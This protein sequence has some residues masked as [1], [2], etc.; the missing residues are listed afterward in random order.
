VAFCAAIQLSS[1]RVGALCVRRL[2]DR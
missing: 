2:G 1:D